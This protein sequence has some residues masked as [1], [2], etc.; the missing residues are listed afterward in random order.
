MEVLYKSTR[1]NSAPVTASQAILKG[2]ADDGGLFVPNN[3]PRLGKGKDT[4]ALKRRLVVIPFNAKFSPED[5][6]YDPF[7]KFKL[8]SEESIQ[9]LIKIGIRGVM[10]VLANN[11]YTRSTKV[12]TEL[13]EFEMENNPLLLFMSD[14]ETK[15]FLNESTGDMYRK[16]DIFCAENN[17]SPV[18]KISFSKQICSRYK[19]KVVSQRTADGV[20]R[21]FKL[22]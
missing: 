21:V 20:I 13:N 5:E 12:E 9:Y 6:D 16:Y 4:H 19:L 8:M 7:I 22:P 18:S 2:L 14:M 11:A 17:I 1:S 3:I 15:D 10:R